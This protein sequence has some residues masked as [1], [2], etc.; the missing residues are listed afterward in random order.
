ML[1]TSRSIQ[2]YSREN[3][4]TYQNIQLPRFD[5]TVIKMEMKILLMATWRE[6]S[7]RVR[8]GLREIIVK[9]SISPLNLPKASKNAK[10]L[11]RVYQAFNLL[12]M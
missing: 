7:I 5:D 10:N 12:I 4:S 11:L 2:I 6:L 3:A 8:I 1:F 9:L